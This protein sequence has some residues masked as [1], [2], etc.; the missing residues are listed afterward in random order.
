MNA[1]KFR[2]Y[3]INNKNNLIPTMWLLM[4]SL[5]GLVFTSLLSIPGGKSVALLVAAIL[6]QRHAVTTMR[7]L[8]ISYVLVCLFPGPLFHPSIDDWFYYSLAHAV[9]LA[10]AAWLIRH[11]DLFYKE[12]INQQQLF[13]SLMIF[14][15]PALTGGLLL[16]RAL[17]FVFEHRLPP[18]QHWLNNW[19]EQLCVVLCLFIPACVINRRRLIRLL[20]VGTSLEY[21]KSIS[22]GIAIVCPILI[23]NSHPFIYL[24]FA[25]AFIIFRR[26]AFYSCL[27]TL[28]VFISCVSL[29]RLGVLP[30]PAVLANTAPLAFW[31]ALAVTMFSLQLI[32]L[33]SELT[34]RSG[35]R[36]AQS[37]ARM[38]GALEFAATGFAL[39]TLQGVIVE[40]NACLCRLLGYQRD[41][42]VGLS[43][44]DLTYPDDISR[45]A[46]CLNEIQRGEMANYQFEKRYQ[47]KDG[48]PLWVYVRVSV[49]DYSQHQR[50]QELIIQIDD[51]TERRAADEALR[52]QANRLRLALS[53]AQA[54][55]WDW[56]LHDSGHWWTDEVYHLLG[57]R[58]DEVAPSQQQW[59]QHVHP[60][61]RPQLER[62]IAD[63]K[64]NRHGY[65][66][67]YRLI[68]SDGAV[69]WIEDHA[70]VECDEQ[71]EVCRIYGVSQD[72]TE[73]ALIEQAIQH[74]EN[75]LRAIL[76]CA[77]DAIVTMDSHGRI[78]SFNPA[79]ERMFGY[80]ES[81]VIGESVSILMPSPHRERHAS[82]L[83]HYLETGKA[84]MIG[85]SRELM[86][87]HRSGKLIPVELSV[88]E[89]STQGERFFTGML[90]DISVHK[91]AEQ[92]LLAAR[93]ELQGVINAASE[94]AIIVT[95]ADGLI[96]L[97][98]SG[99]ERMLG[100]S[101]QEVVALRTPL[102]IHDM[103]EVIDRGLELTAELG[104]PVS[105]FAV[106]VTQAI[107]LGHEVR[108]WTFIRKDRSRLT[109][110]MTVTPIRDQDGC[111]S[112]FLGIAKDISALK[113]TQSELMLAK[114][115]AEA[116]SQ[117]KS[118]FLANMS[119]EIRTPLN[120]VLGIAYLLDGS[121][122]DSQQR[123]YVRMITGAGRSLLQ[124]L[125]DILDFSKIEAGRLD[126]APTEFDL[127]EMMDGLAGIMAVSAANK[128]LDLLIELD[129]AL[130]RCWIADGMRLQQILLNLVG[131][132]IK[133]TH[134]GHVSLQVQATPAPQQAHHLHHVQFVVADSGIGMTPQQV[135]RL[136]VPFSQADSSTT[137]QYGGT[138][139]GLT[140]S[141]RLCEMMGG[142][143][144]VQSQAGVGSRFIVTLPMTPG[145]PR[146]P[147]TI[148]PPLDVALFC[149]DDRHY[150]SLAAA[151][152]VL[153][154]HSQRLTSTAA[155]AALTTEPRPQVLLAHPF[156]D[157]A[158][159]QELDAVCRDWPS[160]PIVVCRLGDKQ[161]IPLSAPQLSTALVLTQ[162]VTAR[163]LQ[164][165]IDTAP[166]LALVTQASAPGPSSRRGQDG[167]ALL[168]DL[169]VLLV[170]DNEVNQMVA[171]RILDQAGARV[172]IANN[173]QE[174]LARLRQAPQRYA[175]V[176]M[177]VQMPVM[178]GFM[179]TRAIRQELG[180]TLPILAMTAGVM[181]DEQAACREAGMDDIIAKPI[182][183]ELMLGTI[184]RYLPRPVAAAG[185]VAPDN[186]LTPALTPPDQDPAPAALDL[187]TLQ[188]TLGED[189]A[190]LTRLLAQFQ[191]ESRQLHQQL[192]AV[193]AQQ[194][195]ETAAR[196]VHTLKGHA[197]TLGAERLAH[198]ARRIEQAIREQQTGEQA[199]LLPELFEA[200]DQLR[201]EVDLWLLRHPQTL[202]VELAQDSEQYGMQ[203]RQFVS[204]LQE[205]NLAALELFDA[206]EPYLQARLSAAEFA[207]LSSAMENLDFQSALIR[208][209]GSSLML[210]SPA[211]TADTTPEAP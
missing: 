57:V 84:R 55:A 205:Q 204:Y 208:L 192:S 13:Q 127:D 176:L 169:S 207:Q 60:E 159:W 37:E 43:L 162:P 177:D 53:I 88:S 7:S 178:D 134:S 102:F 184:S 86:A 33:M 16:E 119:H 156:H 2:D 179:A 174:A 73:R 90:R 157:S 39:T 35:H 70:E 115:Q 151:I 126:L 85:T 114:E 123:Q 25:L 6:Y 164:S 124:I 131:N 113:Q 40:A 166:E 211:Q 101:A 142:Q 167:T 93:A 28:A 82:Y 105:G 80:R 189:E 158:M 29:Y 153:G 117:A 3:L 195:K 108:E 191:I 136:F 149:P 99:A 83:K 210:S 173:G 146:P 52:D 79:A 61:D 11:Y 116:A 196:I 5:G 81:E 141:R 27:V 181:A 128:D 180:L 38:R 1:A 182:D 140:I 143:I 58:R 59:L 12:E 65:R 77:V 51:I 98:N 170:E 21:I 194:D 107:C 118:A 8:V 47:R 74:S 41:E 209:H 31:L 147:L 155:L 188:Q 68:R 148:T 129:P 138:G 121:V 24:V 36:L 78:H 168:D 92:A 111:I 163:A 9:S 71:G 67:T 26:S 72:V 54:G 193:L 190:L 154:G 172:D 50:P 22:L 106:F 14:I 4:A 201:G 206:L 56:H 165:L 120:A 152:T 32:G 48:Q 76:D 144:E 95:N 161:Q 69:L 49:L 15:F 200:L 91:Q 130:P 17:I 139:L 45:S 66:E 133:F 197:G 203:L 89:I 112:G 100:Y 135:A 46:A 137:R 18:P 132:A 145:R 30:R 110:L 104:R 185:A 150:P 34:L 42:L 199:V 75:R 171:S 64:A 97:F 94:I 96:T 186:A 20:H 44:L 198:L 19:L 62:V 160:R 122:L 87:C 202:T 63:A 175:I 187:S 109:A 103:Q 10:G 23:F 183:V 125:N